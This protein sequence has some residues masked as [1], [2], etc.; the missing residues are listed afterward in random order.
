MLISSST[1]KSETICKDV[2]PSISE[3]SDIVFTR[4]FLY[5]MPMSEFGQ[6]LKRIFTKDAQK[7]TISSYISL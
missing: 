2:D 6:K 7:L 1:P 3:S 4:L 5:K